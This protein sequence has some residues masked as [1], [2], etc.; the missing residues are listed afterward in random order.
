MRISTWLNGGAERARAGDAN[1]QAAAP[2]SVN[3]VIFTVLRINPPLKA[4]RSMRYLPAVQNIADD[5]S[6][7]PTLLV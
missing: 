2:S 7:W 3:A 4:A 6:H 5:R 1:Q